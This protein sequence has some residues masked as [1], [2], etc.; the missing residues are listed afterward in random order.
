MHSADFSLLNV[1]HSCCRDWH[2]FSS[3]YLIPA[4]KGT[5]LWVELLKA[6]GWLKQLSCDN[7]LNSAFPGKIEL[8]KQNAK[9]AEIIK[10]T[11]K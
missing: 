5:F 4:L 1:F 9:A 7:T 11:S 3:Y 8:A 2:L 6:C 10:G